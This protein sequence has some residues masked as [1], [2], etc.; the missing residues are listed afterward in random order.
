M[1]PNV[2][3]GRV[4]GVLLI[5]AGIA[6]CVSA[7]K[8]RKRGEIILASLR[9][10]LYV[11]AGGLL[12][13]NVLG[14][15]Y[16]AFLLILVFATA[17]RTVRKWATTSLLRLGVR[18]SRRGSRRRVERL[19]SVMSAAT[20]F[21]LPLHWRVA[22][23]MQ[24][25]GVYRKG[26]PDLYFERAAD[27]MEFLMHIF[28]A[29]FPESGVAQRFSFD[30]SIRLLHQAHSAGHG[31]LVISPHLCGYPV[32]PRVLAEHVPCS[33]YLR[34]SADPRK[35]EIN[36]QIGHAGGGHL[37][38]PP[39]DASPMQRIT[40]AMDILRAKRALYITPDLPRKPDEGVPVT[41]F[42]RTVYFPTGVV[43]MAMRTRA[44]IVFAAWHCENGLYHV[45]FHPPL[46]FSPRG[47]RQR[48]AASGMAEFARL[49]DEQ[50]HEHPEMWWNWLDKRWT[51]ILRSRPGFE[52][53]RATTESAAHDSAGRDPGLRQPARGDRRR[54]AR[55][56]LERGLRRLAP[57]LPWHFGRSDVTPRR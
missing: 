55:D 35:H 20:K 57:P 30:S 22:R 27:Q 52:D 7:R 40:V 44:P 28:R 31:T 1:L 9:G 34:H 47:D 42:G 4:I 8:C 13:M 12:L 24:R 5:A 10:A 29:G 14:A 39:I 3:I 54:G 51:R 17:A 19:R 45:S 2:P 48:R 25:A 37:V 43:I 38:Y 15:A 41:V 32:F 6:Q 16:T 36:R 18:L 53:L 49:M 33:I 26:L 50:L 23:N 46:D 56:L 11:S 21:C